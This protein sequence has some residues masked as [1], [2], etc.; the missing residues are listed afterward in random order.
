MKLLL[1]IDGERREIPVHAFEISYNKYEEFD[2]VIIIDTPAA[3]Q[4]KVV[5]ATDV[6]KP[7]GKGILA[8][9]SDV[10]E[11]VILSDFYIDNAS[12]PLTTAR[13]D[14]EVAVMDSANVIAN[15]DFVQQNIVVSS[16]S[17][18]ND[19]I[20]NLLGMIPAAC[21]QLVERE[22]VAVGD[23][24]LYIVEEPYLKKDDEENK[25]K[26]IEKISVVRRAVE[27][28]EQPKE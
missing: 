5:E 1:I 6:R 27:A 4:N 17:F 20:F 8:R 7:S 24:Y 16:D 18:E 25:Y 23:H 14:R 19:D 21:N 15:E 10:S 28:S 3:I 2:T 12:N 22:K 13:I 9:D 11:T 26:I